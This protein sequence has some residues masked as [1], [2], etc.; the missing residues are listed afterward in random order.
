MLIIG[1]GRKHTPK[2]FVNSCESFIYSEILSNTINSNELSNGKDIES[3]NKPSVLD[4]K[5]F[6]ETFQ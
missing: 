5:L 6:N 2:A 1:I 4:R 3:V